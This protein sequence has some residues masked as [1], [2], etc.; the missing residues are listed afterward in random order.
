M[1]VGLP[2]IASYVVMPLLSLAIL[3]AFTR[4]LRGRSLPDRVV[5]LDLLVSFGIG[6]VVVKAIRDREP[7]LLDV[8]VILALV[9]F[10]GTVAFA[11]YLEASRK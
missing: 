7:V 11:A 10:L 3:I 5:A 6:I 9:A 4:L 1:S 8:A 2:S